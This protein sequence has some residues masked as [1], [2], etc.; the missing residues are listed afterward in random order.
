MCESVET[1]SVVTNDQEKLIISFNKKI[2][3]WNSVGSLCIDGASSMLSE[4]R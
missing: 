3:S 4:L 2:N 1:T